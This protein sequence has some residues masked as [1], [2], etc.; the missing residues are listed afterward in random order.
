M[1]EQ[2][3]SVINVTFA[4]KL[5]TGNYENE[6]YRL[7]ISQVV[8]P[9]LSQPELVQEAEE[10]GRMVKAQAYTEAGV[11]CAFLIVPLITFVSFSRYTRLPVL[12]RYDLEEQDRVLYSCGVGTFCA[13]DGRN[14]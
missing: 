6:E 13:P 14:P 2:Q 11:E 12:I 4:T 3:Q 7:S 10:L 8:D 1:T 5:S 9:T